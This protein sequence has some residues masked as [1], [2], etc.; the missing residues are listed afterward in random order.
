MKVVYYLLIN[1]LIL[2]SN[3]TKYYTNGNVTKKKIQKNNEK[4]QLRKIG[5]LDISYK[6][7]HRVYYYKT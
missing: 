5:K 7:C 4:N 1:F 2:Q 3:V 6:I